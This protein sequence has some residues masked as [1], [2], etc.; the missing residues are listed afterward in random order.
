MLETAREEKTQSQVQ[1]FRA[2]LNGTCNYILD[3]L[4]TG[5]SFQDA[6]NEAQ[7]LGF[8]EADPSAD[9]DGFDAARKCALLAFEAWGHV[10]DWRRIELEGIRPLTTEDARNATK[11]GAVTSIGCGRA[12]A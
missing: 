7:A 6:L 1:Q 11:S 2:V 3:R 9:I 10:I 4:H 12:S 8:A 5:E